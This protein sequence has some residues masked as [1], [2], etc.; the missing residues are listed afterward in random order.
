M[1]DNDLQ[2]S[3]NF[4]MPNPVDLDGE[5]RLTCICCQAIVFSSIDYAPGI[6]ISLATLV[7]A[8]E[9]HEQQVAIQ[10]RGGQP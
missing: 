9:D 4:R 8:A 5:V 2:Y 7:E 10:Q 6:T 3:D 1:A